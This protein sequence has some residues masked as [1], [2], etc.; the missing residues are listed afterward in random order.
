[1]VKKKNCKKSRGQVT[2]FAQCCNIKCRPTEHQSHR[3]QY[4]ALACSDFACRRVLQ[5]KPG[6][7]LEVKNSGKETALGSLSLIHGGHFL[8]G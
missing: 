5:S 6:S 4:Q 8:G 7:G 3:G 1:M 2:G